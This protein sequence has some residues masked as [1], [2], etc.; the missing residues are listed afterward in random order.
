MGDA[1]KQ[2]TDANALLK[3]H[4]SDQ[5]LLP[6]MDATFNDEEKAVELYIWDRRLG[7]A[8]FHDL[9][10]LEIALRNALDR[11]LTSRYG[12]DWFRMSSALFDQ[13][14]YNQIAEAWERLPAKYRNGARGDGK[15]RGRLIASCM[16]GTWTSALDAGGAAGPA[17]GPCTIANHDDVWTRDVLLSAFPAA[18]KIAGSEREQLTR[19]W[20]YQQVREVHVLRNRVA[21]HESLINGYPIPGTGS[22]NSTPVRRKADE[23]AR[24]CDQLAKMI[25]TKLAEFID[26][27]SEVNVVLGLDP[28]KGWGFL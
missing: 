20:V 11:A 16:F 15:I 21:H 26:T 24:A 8:F 4:L 17:I 27:N 3:T 7:T 1:A 18:R 14:T 25:D 5:R 6:Y 22:E 2:P 10:V 28:R 23:G 13:R 9:S 12:P 19:H